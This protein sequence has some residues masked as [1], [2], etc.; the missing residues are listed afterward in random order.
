MTDFIPPHFDP[1]AL[2]VARLV[3]PLRLR[4]GD[5]VTR[6]EIDDTSL[7]RLRA[8]HGQRV[9]LC[10]NHSYQADAVVLY[11]LSLMVRQQ[12]YYLS[13]LENFLPPLQGWLLRNVGAYS[14]VRGTMDLS[15]F[16]CTRHLLTAGAH[17]IVIFPEGEIVGQNDV[18]GA[19]QP[20]VAQFAFWALDDLRAGERT[21]PPVYAAPVTMKYLLPG[22]V[23]PAL[24]RRMA[25]MERK[26]NLTDPRSDLYDRLGKIGEAV[27]AIAEREYDLT[28]ATG[29]LFNDRVQAAK[30]AILARVA[31]EV[32]VTL[33]P[34]RTTV[35]HVRMLFNAID[36]ITRAV[37]APTA[38]ARKLQR[39]HQRRLNALYVD[40]WRV[41]RFA[42]TFDGYNP[43]HLTQERLMELT[44]RLEWEILGS[45]RW[46]GPMT[47]IVHVGDPINL[48]DY[49][50]GYRGN[51]HAA[52][53]VATRQLAT[54]IQ[55]KLTELNG[56]MT[57]MDRMR[58]LAIR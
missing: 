57:P 2:F 40:L 5:R 26:L 15:C 31:R 20:G 37:P 42:A 32:N 6:L 8:L 36:R 7:A 11:A 47:A 29:A 27:L 18:I 34:D 44:N 22:D 21:L 51:K 56:R 55:E 54:A 33:R 23:R 17:P 45:L 3:L 58:P 19:F 38:Y 1:F 41:L 14:V 28:P 13:A 43:E 30:V 25:L 53:A 52:L 49:Y 48:T 10:P 9:M 24:A 4:G 16:R 12:W 50:D 46:V 39:E 35:D